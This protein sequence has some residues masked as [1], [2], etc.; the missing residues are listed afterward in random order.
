MSWLFLLALVVFLVG[1]AL[2][3]YV[4]I[5]REYVSI[6]A[7]VDF[8]FVDETTYWFFRPA[9]WIYEQS[10]GREVA[11]NPMVDPVPR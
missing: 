2:G 10:T 3:Y 8:L 1:Y 5:H 6:A 9:I 11:P 7:G 4:L